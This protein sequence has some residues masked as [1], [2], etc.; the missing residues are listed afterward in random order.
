MKPASREEEK[1]IDDS[2]YVCS[3]NPTMLHCVSP[4]P[5]AWVQSVTDKHFEKI[6]MSL[7]VTE[8]E[9][10][11]IRDLTGDDVIFKSIVLFDIQMALQV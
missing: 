9:G 1:E 11:K 6:R 5:P 3:V 10:K 8:I 4:P 7:K 2:V